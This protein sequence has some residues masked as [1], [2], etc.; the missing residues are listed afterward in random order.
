MPSYTNFTF[1]ED[2]FTEKKTILN[3]SKFKSFFF[4]NKLI[5]KI[6]LIF[7]FEYLFKN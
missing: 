1:N 6:M 7:N 2:K 4:S 5:G 3:L